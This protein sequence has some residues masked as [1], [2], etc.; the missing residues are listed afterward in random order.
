[1]TRSG[2]TRHAD[3]PKR[4]GH[5]SGRWSPDCTTGEPD[6]FE[7]FQSGSEGGGGNG[8]LRQPRRP[9][10]LCLPL[11]RSR[12]D[13]GEE[14]LDSLPEAGIT[15]FAVPRDVQDFDPV[16]GKPGDDIA[17]PGD[18]LLDDEVG[19]AVLPASGD[20]RPITRRVRA[21]EPERPV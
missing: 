8:A 1:M 11:F 6:E 10:T 9:P 3:L 2:G 20:G 5:R 12:E 15:R 17:R 18:P 19:L 16:G 4:Y 13:P 7:R 14:P 21:A